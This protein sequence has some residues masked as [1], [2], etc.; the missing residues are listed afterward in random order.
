[1]IGDLPEDRN[2]FS[3]VANTLRSRD[4]DEYAI[5]LYD[6]G[7]AISSMNYKF[8]ME[9][10]L[11]GIELLTMENHVGM[12]IDLQSDKWGV[13][14]LHFFCLGEVIVWRERKKSRKRN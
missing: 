13:R 4:F 1:M 3:Q 10:A 8:Y 7:S 2:V 5:I 11:V 9:K 12:V 6:R 14:A